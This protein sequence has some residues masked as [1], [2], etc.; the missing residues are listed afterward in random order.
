MMASDIGIL[1]TTSSGPNSEHQRGALTFETA[2]ARHRNM[3]IASIGV[4]T[5]GYLVML[6][7]SR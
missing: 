3:A 4:G 6:F 2:K 1:A 5:V 7:H